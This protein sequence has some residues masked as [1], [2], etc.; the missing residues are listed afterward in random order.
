[1]LFCVV[2]FLAVLFCAVL[3]LATAALVAVV[4]FAEVAPAVVLAAAFF[5]GEGAGDLADRVDVVAATVAGVC[6]AA[7]TVAGAFFAADRRAGTFF[8]GV[9]V[10][11]SA[12]SSAAR[13][14][15][16]DSTAS[17]LRN[18]ALVTPSVAYGPN[19]PSLTTICSPETGSG[20]SSRSG[21]AACR[22]RALGCA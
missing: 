3:F 16:R 14:R 21:A 15:V 7:A 8:A 6:F 13:Y 1:V 12:N 2:L 17:S 22:P 18:V 10:R 19:R 5:V 20:P 4:V 9:R 11:L